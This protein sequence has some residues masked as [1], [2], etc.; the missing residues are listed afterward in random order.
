MDKSQRTRRGFSPEF[1]VEAVRRVL[2]R[3]LK[4]IS[5]AQLA[6]ELEV[7]PDLPRS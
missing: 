1:K 3:Q 2:E 7:R 5:L 4:E 6:R